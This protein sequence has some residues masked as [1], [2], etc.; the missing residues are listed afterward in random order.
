MAGNHN[1]HVLWNM[2]TEL[3]LICAK[4]RRCIAEE[5]AFKGWQGQINI[6]YQRIL[7]ENFSLWIRRI[8]EIWN[9]LCI[10]RWY[11]TR[12]WYL[13]SRHLFPSNWEKCMFQAT[14]QSSHYA[15]QTT[16]VSTAMLHPYWLVDWYLGMLKQS[17]KT[18]SE[19]LNNASLMSTYRMKLRQSC[20][21]DKVDIIEFVSTDTEM[22]KL[23]QVL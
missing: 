12:R 8:S 15:W 18:V 13:C 5:A 3:L 6:N 14:P 2:A 4:Y 21:A 19:A 16:A 17:T 20:R 22:V 23:S 9:N 10:I 11:F 1:T 7:Y